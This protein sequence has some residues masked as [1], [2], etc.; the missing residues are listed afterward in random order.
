M[1]KSIEAKCTGHTAEFPKARQA[2]KP[3]HTRFSVCFQGHSY[4][5]RGYSHGSVTPGVL[6]SI[7][8]GLDSGMR[9]CHC[10][11]H[12]PQSKPLLA[13]WS[14]ALCVLDHRLLCKSNA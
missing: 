13:C 5:T 8:W 6:Q 11:P 10:S 2:K 7:D 3:G 1:R 4:G 9:D 14:S 12:R